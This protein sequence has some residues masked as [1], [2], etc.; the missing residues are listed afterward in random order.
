[1]AIKLCVT[2]PEK[3]L[4]TPC[5]KCHYSIAAMSFVS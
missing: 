1:M 2:I 3:V 4:Y 5:P